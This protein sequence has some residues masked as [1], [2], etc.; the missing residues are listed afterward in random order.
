MLENNHDDHGTRKPLIFYMVIVTTILLLLNAFVIPLMLA[1]QVQAIGYSDFL[2]W[3]EEGRVSE[4]SLSQESDQIVFVAKNDE[5]QEELYKTALFPDDGLIERLR[6][7]GV[8]FSAEIP[9]QNNTLLSF[10]LSWILMFL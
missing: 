5:G 4:V 2:K 8:R 1:R 6:Q 9:T 7:A 10:L 3:V